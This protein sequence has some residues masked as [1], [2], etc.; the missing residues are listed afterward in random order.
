MYVLNPMMCVQNLQMEPQ[1]HCLLKDQ[2]GF[3]LN[4]GFLPHR[5][6]AVLMCSLEPLL[7]PAMTT[8]HV[9]GASRDRAEVRTG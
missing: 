6:I 8:G 2:V 7:G 9:L 5:L 3:T 4:H 1:N